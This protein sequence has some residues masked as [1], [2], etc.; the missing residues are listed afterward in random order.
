MRLEL[1]ISYFL[2]GGVLFA[3]A[4]VALG[5]GMMLIQG[6]V[7]LEVYQVYEEQ[8]FFEMLHWAFLLQQTGVLMVALGLVVLVSLPVLRV[9]LTG[10][11]LL[12]NR[13]WIVGSV[14]IFVFMALLLSFAMGL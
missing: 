11:L 14:S 10:I 13:E 9:L 3:G 5:F 1:W 4:L 8:S 6:G 12:V 7:S 2:R